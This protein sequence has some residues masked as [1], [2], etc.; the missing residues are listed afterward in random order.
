MPDPEKLLNTLQRAVQAFRQT[1][2]RRGKCVQIEGASEVLVAG[3]LHGNLDNFRV[4]LQRADL[5]KHPTRHLV[6]QEVIHSSHAYPAGGDKS[7]QLLDLTAALKAQYP[8]R[9]HF[10]LGNHEL[11]QW[12]DRRIGKGDMDYNDFFREGVQTAYGERADEVYAGYE[13][14]FAAAPLVLRTDNRVLI[15]HSLP[16]ESR[17]NT[18]DRNVLY[19]DDLEERDVIPGGT[20]HSLVWG[21]DTRLSNATTYLAMFDADLLIS[22]HIPCDAGFDAPSER[23]LILDSLGSPAAYCLFPADRPLTHAELLDCVRMI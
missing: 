16:Q 20:V 1:P 13:T 12:T 3:D 9:V 5:A 19:R 17:L 23:Q 14:L 8:H 2:G 22:G 18:F 10:L 4:I 6:L 15:S 11:A 21:R 7:H